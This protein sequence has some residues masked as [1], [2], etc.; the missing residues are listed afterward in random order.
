VDLI[1]SRGLP[2]TH[3]LHACEDCNAALVA[4]GWQS[5]P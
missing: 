1:R 3:V 5:L 4:Q 2:S